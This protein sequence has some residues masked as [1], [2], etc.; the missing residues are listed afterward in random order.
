MKIKYLI[1]TIENKVTLEKKNKNVI[2]KNCIYFNFLQQTN[3]IL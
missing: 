2:G 1:I 3:K